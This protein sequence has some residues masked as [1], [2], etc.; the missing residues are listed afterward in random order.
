MGQGPHGQAQGMGQTHAHSL[1][2]MISGTISDAVRNGGGGFK[3]E[4]QAHAQVQGRALGD[5]AFGQARL[6]DL[7]KKYQG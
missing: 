1:P 4:G 6:R 3:T 7:I 2:P 5:L